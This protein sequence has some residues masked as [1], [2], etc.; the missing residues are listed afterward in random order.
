M[1]DK[2]CFWNSLQVASVRP[3]LRYAEGFALTRFGWQHHAWVV[4]DHGHAID[5]T[6][7]EPGRRY[8]GVAFTSTR[9]ALTAMENHQG[10]GGPAL[11]LVSGCQ[12]TW[13]PPGE[14]AL[15]GN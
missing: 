13:H 4:D 15:T 11:K 9:Q 12:Y 2:A 3:G 5:V 14:E 10:L 6:W 1:R 7:A 8:I